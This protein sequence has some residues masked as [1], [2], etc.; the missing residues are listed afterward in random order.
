MPIVEEIIARTPF[1]APKLR[2]DPAVTNFYDFTPDSVK[3]EGYQCHPL[4]QSIP[5]AV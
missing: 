1:E 5:V 4:D 3:L 2:L